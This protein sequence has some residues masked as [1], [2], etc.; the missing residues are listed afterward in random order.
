MDIS[1][2]SV[3]T[4]LSL[5][6]PPKVYMFVWMLLSVCPPLSDLFCCSPHSHQI[7]S[8]N[9][10][11]TPQMALVSLH[12]ERLMESQKVMEKSSIVQGVCKP[13]P[14]QCLIKLWDGAEGG[15]LL[16][17]HTQS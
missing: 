10:M 3:F 12:R 11:L 8:G 9:E 15:G 13:A 17:Q 16:G 7:C 1:S 2:S 14:S 4:F 6:V 5:W